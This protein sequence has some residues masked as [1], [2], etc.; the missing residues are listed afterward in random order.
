MR[1]RLA[2]VVLVAVAITALGYGVEAAN[3][4]PRTVLGPGLVTVDI[5][6]EH[7]RF[8]VDRIDVHEGTLVRFVVRNDDPIPHELVVGGADVH[9]RH[10]RGTER[11]HPPV[12]GEVSL[13]P[14]ETGETFYRFDDV[15]TFEF[16]CH[17]P[18]HLAYGMRGTVV[19]S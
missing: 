19:V 13:F 8:D 1:W 2:T 14:N 11:V 3:G 18:G 17:L 6:I 9:A 4:A 5:T 10:E 7:S 16:M 12:P 15:G